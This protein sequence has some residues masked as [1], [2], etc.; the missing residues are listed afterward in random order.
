MQPLRVWAQA[1]EYLAP[2]I[3]VLNICVFSW[4]SG[5]CENIDYSEYNIAKR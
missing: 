1:E 2:D 5:T 3:T 4:C